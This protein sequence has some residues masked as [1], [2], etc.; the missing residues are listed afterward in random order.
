MHAVRQ[1]LLAHM[2]AGGH[3]VG[4]GAHL[5]HPCYFTERTAYAVAQLEH[6]RGRLSFIER[7]V[8]EKATRHVTVAENIDAEFR[9]E[10][11]LAQRAADLL[12][13]RG[14]SWTFVITLCAALVGWLFVNSISRE[15]FDPY[16]FILL[17]LILSCIA[18]LQAP[19]ILM[20][21]NR[22]AE[23]DRRKADQDFLVNLKAEIEVAS[24][25]EKVD[26]LLHVQWDRMVE[27][28]E[29]QL[30]MLRALLEQSP[31]GGGSRH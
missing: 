7:E 12:A 20:S 18:A 25:H 14:G 6:D 22:Q 27:M 15:A 17:N 8:A 13:R 31:R 1:S 4:P 26:H 11:T 3:A 5:C 24:L 30:E 2:A 9:R 21:A 16:P 28:Q 19:V 23:H 29:L 10:A